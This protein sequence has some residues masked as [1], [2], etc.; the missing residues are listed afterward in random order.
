VVGHEAQMR[1]KR[2][3]SS[4]KIPKGKRIL[5]SHRSREENSIKIDRREYVRKC[6]VDLSGSGYMRLKTQRLCA[7]QMLFTERARFSISHT[8]HIIKYY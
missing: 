1:V 4:V 7:S 3:A 2:V 8:M 6:G 5:E